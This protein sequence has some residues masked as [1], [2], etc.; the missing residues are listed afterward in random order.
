MKFFHGVR[1]MYVYCTA[2]VLKVGTSSY[3]LVACTCKSKQH[4]LIQ[5]L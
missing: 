2:R 1:D 4:V 5:A 3:R